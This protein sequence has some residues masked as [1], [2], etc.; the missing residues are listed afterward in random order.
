[1]R[2]GHSSLRAYITLMG[3]VIINRYINKITFDN[4]NSLEE[5]NTGWCDRK[6]WGMHLGRSWSGSQEVDI[7]KGQEGYDPVATEER[8]FRERA[9]LIC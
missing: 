6:Y 8:M 3:I 1:M 9:W 4:D 5:N 2:K 7:R